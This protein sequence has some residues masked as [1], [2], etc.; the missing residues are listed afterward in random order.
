MVQENWIQDLCLRASF[1]PQR[2]SDDNG[3]LLGTL[4]EFF[5]EK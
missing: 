1:T 5:P 4:E 2:F 3:S